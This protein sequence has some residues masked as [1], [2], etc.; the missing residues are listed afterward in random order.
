MAEA[1][2]E[3][4]AAGEALPDDLF[5]QYRDPA[6]LEDYDRNAR[7][8]SPEQVRQI[9][10]SM[11]E[12]KVYNPIL[13]RDDEKTIG[14]GHGRK[15]AALLKPAIARVPTITLRGLTDAQWRAL[16]IADNK[17]A[18]NAG[19]NE[20]ILRM[21]LGDLQ[22]EGFDLSITGFSSLELTGFFTTEEGQTDPDAAPE[23]PA[24]PVSRLGDLWR[25]GDHLLICG[26]CTEKEVV[27][28]VLAGQKPH[29]MVTDPPYGV[30]YDPAWRSAALK[31]GAKR[32]EG[33][34]QNDHQPDWREAWGL[35]PGEVAYIWHDAL[36]C[37]VVSEGLRA[38]A[39]DLRSQ[40]IWNKGAAAIGRGHYHWKHEACFYAVR[41]GG[42]GHWAGDRKQTTVWDIEHRK[43]ETGHSTQKPVEA[44][45]R[46][47]RNNSKPGDRIFDPFCGSGSSIIAAQMNKRI[48]HA[49][50][51]NPA[52]VDVALRRFAEFTGVAPIL[53]E[54][55]Q[56]FEQ[57]KAAR[58]DVV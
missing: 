31:D 15:L 19:W 5:I 29:L 25:L 48:T 22:A 3:L 34:V 46:P 42:N 33:Q 10:R 51:L 45:A 4:A 9:R 36:A 39:F 40:I 30:D 49:I 7:T 47:I 37:G 57:V 27:D 23:P 18:L 6:S 56:T 13:L 54:T 12:F 38:A 41:K 50:E 26:D 52:Y 11:D 55:E 58:F 32:A 17:L 2:P 21:E 53:A 24:I 44:M 20:N 43:S 1:R 35:F 16:V 8:H 28:R 14:A